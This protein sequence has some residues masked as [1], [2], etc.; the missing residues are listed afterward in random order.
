MTAFTQYVWRKLRGRPARPASASSTTI[1]GQSTAYARRV[2]ALALGGAAVLVGGFVIDRVIYS[3]QLQEATRRL[4]LA[5]QA[6][7]DIRL[8]DERL[9]M[10]ANMAAATAERRWID[11]YDR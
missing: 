2:V 9:T 3:R 6:A 8:A 5:E 10:S 1:V 4:V 11:R 7:G